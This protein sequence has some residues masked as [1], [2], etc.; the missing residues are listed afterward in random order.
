MSRAV[1]LELVSDLT[2]EAFMRCFRRFVARRGFP[3]FV[4]SDHGKTFE[5][6]ARELCSIAQSAECQ[7]FSAEHHIQWQFN[8]EKAPWWGGFF[9]RLVQS[10]KRCLRKV[11]GNAYV[12]GEELVTVLAEV[13]CTLNSRPLTF[14]STEEWTE[15]LTPSHLL[16]GRRLRSMPDAEHIPRAA[17]AEVVRERAEHLQ[18]LIRHSWT[19]WRREYLLELRNAHR[20]QFNANAT[21]IRV[22]DVVL[23]EDENAK[24]QQWPL[25]LVVELIPGH[26]GIARA[27]KVKPQHRRKVALRT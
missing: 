11:L 9:E 18:Q 1:H 26:D 27:A 12:S 10:V 23:I 25:G 16:L 19:R 7:Q 21:P 6:A 4:I 13:E 22:G 3:C 14:L 20:Q 8:V 24:R 15:P 17:T 2:T 5:A